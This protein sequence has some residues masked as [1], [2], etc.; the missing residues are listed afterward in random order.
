MNYLVIFI[1]ILL[2][3][4]SCK[5]DE[6]VKIGILMSEQVG[7]WKID[8]A[9][10]REKADMY[11]AETFFAWGTLDPA[12]Q[13]QQ[14]DSILKLE[15]DVLIFVPSDAEVGAEIVSKAH[16]MDIPVISYDR[17]ALNC[18]LDYYITFDNLK[19]GEFQASY[20]YTKVPTGKYAIISGPVSDN[21]AILFRDGQ[22]NVLRQAIDSGQ[23]EV[24]Y[25]E[26]AVAWQEEEGYKMG[27]EVLTNYPDVDAFLAANDKFA[28]GI[29]KAKHE[30]DIQKDII[31]TGQDADLINLAALITGEQSMTIYK[32]LEA[33]G[34]T[35]IINAVK[36]A[37]NQLIRE[38][39][40]KINNGYKEVPSILLTP[41][42]I[43][44]R[45]IR[46]VLLEDSVVNEA[47]I[48]ALLPDSIPFN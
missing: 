20:A 15:P 33:S 7:R 24:I 23:I 34:Y 32:S 1:A 42:M 25:D 11:G 44:R 2:A 4:S 43:D 13:L 41:I 19:V 22:L 8:S 5:N 28:R 3:F 36:I 16:K 45:N 17:L 14:A 30:L 9:M 26:H 38:A 12:T 40:F 47:D 10:M 39:N 21:N 31:I 35:A 6:T 29:I 18:D 27:K 48:V 37:R 46:S